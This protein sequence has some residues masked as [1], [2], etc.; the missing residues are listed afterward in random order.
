M[1]AAAGVSAPFSLG[2]MPS[3]RSRLSVA[4]TVIAMNA[5]GLIAFLRLRSD[6]LLAAVID[7]LHPDHGTAVPLLFANPDRDIPVVPLLVNYSCSTVPEP[8]EC[9]QF[10]RTLVEFIRTMRP[11]G[12]RV[13]LIGAGGLSH[14]VG[15]A[16]PRVNEAF[17]RAFLSAV[18]QSALEDWRSR[19]ATEIEREG[20]N[21][22]LEIMSWLA[23][24]AATPGAR[25]QI[26]YYEP[27]LA[28]MTGMGGAVLR[29]TDAASS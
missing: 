6:K 8:E 13:A 14:W 12:E 1:N 10:G 16:E 24:L 17:D 20:G 18:E 9:W 15:Y 26:T 25:A 22:G 5:L 7:P 23:V 11:A 4:I 2:R 28:W 21:G 29:L 19:S 27:M 3:R